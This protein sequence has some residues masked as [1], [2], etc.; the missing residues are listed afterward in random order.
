VTAWENEADAILNQL[1][2]TEA[3]RPSQLP[4]RELSGAVDDAM[5]CLERGMFFL[6]AGDGAPERLT[7]LS[8]VLVRCA[9]EF[10]KGLAILTDGAA[11]PSRDDLPEFFESV[12]RLDTM[13]RR[14]D[15]LERDYLRRIFDL[16]LSAGQIERWREI[17][18]QLALAVD[19]LAR[20][21]FLLYDSV[22]QRRQVGG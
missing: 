10:Y 20:A 8:G 12:G 16:E 17:G 6:A 11:E 22:F 3:R 7:A 2:R 9:Q 13:S 4:V 14:K 15:E 18:S 21:A 1:R 5:D 19:H